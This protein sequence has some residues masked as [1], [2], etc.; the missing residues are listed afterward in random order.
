MTYFIKAIRTSCFT[1]EEKTI[2]I[3]IEVRAVTICSEREIWLFIIDG[4]PTGY[5][6]M[7]VDRLQEATTKEGWLANM[8]TKG[9][10]D[11]LFIPSAELVKLQGLIAHD[12]LLQQPYK[13]EPDPELIQQQTSGKPTPIIP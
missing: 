9:R 7:P 10:W 6:S 3:A 4:G 2:E 5:E 8:G 1:Q 12:A 13:K 11:K